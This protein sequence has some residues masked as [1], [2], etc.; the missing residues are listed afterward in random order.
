MW[1]YRNVVKLLL[2][3]NIYIYMLMVEAITTNC[4][5]MVPTVISR[6]LTENVRLLDDAGANAKP[7]VPIPNAEGEVDRGTKL[8]ALT[9]CIYI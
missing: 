2:L 7:V 9:D 4:A 8:L 3:Q 5:P 1:S 6:L